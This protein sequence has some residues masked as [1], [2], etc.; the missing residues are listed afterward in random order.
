ML[1]V[2][3]PRAEV[4]D[5]GGAQSTALGEWW[6]PRRPCLLKFVQKRKGGAGL[7][8]LAFQTK[9]SVAV[10]ADEDWL[11]LSTGG[12]KRHELSQPASSSLSRKASFA[13]SIRGPCPFCGYANKDGRRC[14]DLT[15]LSPQCAGTR[16]AAQGVVLCFF[17]WGFSFISSDFFVFLF[18]FVA[19]ALRGILC[20]QA[21][22]VCIFEAEIGIHGSTPEAG[23]AIAPARSRASLGPVAR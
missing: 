11:P 8:A 4:G 10:G 13:G 21:R 15:D 17:S 6:D 22:S 20:A 7:L 1:V 12:A 5:L 14:L 9:I 3:S 16:A 23:D 18:F 2:R 19:V